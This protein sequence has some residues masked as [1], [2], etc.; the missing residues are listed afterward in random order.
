MR[1][2]A[3]GTRKN[4]CTNCHIKQ[5]HN[6]TSKQ[7]NVQCVDCHGGHVDV[8]DG[9]KPNVWLI[10]RY[11]N[12]STVYGAVRNKPVFFLTTANA[13]KNY[14]DANGTGVCQAC[15]TIPPGVASE[16]DDSTKNGSDCNLCHNH[17]GGSS[18]S[19][20]CTSCH[21]FPPVANVVG[22][23]NGYAAGYMGTGNG[24]SEATSP[25]ARHAGKSTN[26][27]FGCSECHYGNTHN[28]A[29]PTYQDVFNSAYSAGVAWKAG[30]SPSY[31]KDT[32]RNCSNVYCHSNGAPRN[33]SLTPVL[34]WT[35]IKWTSPSTS[36]TCSSCH[37][38][39]PATN[40][41]ARH[42]SAMGYNCVVCHAGT[43]DAANAIIN[44]D[45][46]VD[47]VKTVVWQ[48]GN[49]LL[50]GGQWSTSAATCSTLYCHSNGRSG[51]PNQTPQWTDSATGQC[52]DCHGFPMTN[53]GHPGHLTATYGPKFGTTAPGACDKCHT[54]TNETAS[55]HVDGTLNMVTNACTTCHPIAGTYLWTSTT[56]VTCVS[57]HSGGTVSIIGT[58]SAPYKD[59]TLFA[60]GGHGQAGANYD[61]S[62]ACE[63]CHNANSDHIN[64]GG[65]TKRL[66]LTNDNTLCSSCHND[67]AKVPTVGKQNMKTHVMTHAEAVAETPTM[68][69]KA[70]HDVHGTPNLGMILST[71]ASKPITF[72]NR[73]SGYVVSNGS[74]LCQVCHSGL[75][76]YNLNQP[77]TSF[78]HPTKNCLSCHSHKNAYAFK[79]QACNE[80]HGYPPVPK[81]YSMSTNNYQYGKDED[82]NDGGGA[83]VKAGH[84]NPAAKPSDG[85]SN[86][87]VCHSDGSMSPGTHQL[88]NPPYPPNKPTQIDITI[89]LDDNYKFNNSHPLGRG[90]YSGPLN[91]QWTTGNSTGYCSN[92]SCHFQRTPRWGSF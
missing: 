34:T 3:D 63:T 1:G 5:N 42:V 44:K 4:I 15:H 75:K 50:T 80:C 16:H 29:T 60:S 26:Y 54:Y 52:G 79:P 83:H 57:C 72:G 40:A 38:A 17:S 23:P 30:A 91:G 62:R 61:A 59:S 32:N 14:R 56:R 46:H 70:C 68:D 10:N 33:A 43:V 77:M 47:G 9:S 66:T 85:W 18:F 39:S 67:P 76:Y 49:P 53:F 78:S 92:V 8:G 48:S 20:G 64:V 51:P 82:Y 7:Q 11:M 71:I 81:G 35:S 58:H 65:G 13:S 6:S 74:G 28:Q 12:I 22:G 25:H 45:N 41:H 73:S 84:V 27:S 2:S 21:G 69:C 24:I 90:Q 88:K 87:A 36:L 55:T 37:A 19:G 89:D 86:C 31:P